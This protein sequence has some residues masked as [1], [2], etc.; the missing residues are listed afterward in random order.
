MLNPDQIRQKAERKYQDVLRAIVSGEPV[1]PLL[2]RFG[3]PSPS[4][5]FAKLKREIEELATGNFG[6]QIVYESVNTRRWGTQRLPTQVSFDTEAQYLRALK[7]TSE[8]VAFRA[9]LEESLRRLP[10]LKPWLTSR[11]K[12]VV[13]F[14]GDWEGILRVC[15]FFLKNPKPDLYIRQL[16]IQVHTKFIQ[17]HSEVLTSLLLFLLPEGAKNPAAKSFEMKFGLRPLEPTIRFRSL[18]PEVTTKLRMTEN[19]MGL[20]LDR[21]RAL[22]A[23][24]LRVIITENLMNLECLPSIAGT[25][26][27]W[28]Q[29]NAA[30]LL[31]DVEWLAR[32]HVV[33]WGDIDEHGFHILARLRTHYP[34]LHSVMMDVET[35][36]RFQSLCGLGEKAGNAPKNLTSMEAEACSQVRQ[37][38]SRLEQEKIPLS[39]SCQMLSEAIEEIENTAWPR[40]GED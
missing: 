34:K 22:P 26:A 21:F 37:A 19:R 32:C 16:P 13:D 35:L 25:L 24:G 27:I 39:Y 28:G 8:V 15:E 2:V 31:H 6:Y 14:A 18:D 20:P 17:E 9:N 38:N 3:Q 33:Y 5:D 40:N 30:D 12:W 11:V 4:D 23:S 1:F 29:G 36:R 7:K 10:Q